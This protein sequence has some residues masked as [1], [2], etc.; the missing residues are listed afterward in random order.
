M[1]SSRPACPTVRGRAASSL[2]RA[3]LESPGT[4]SVI[5]IGQDQPLVAPEG[6]DVGG[7]ALQIDVVFG[8]DLEM[9]GDGWVN[10]RE[11]RP[12]RAHLGPAD[13]GIGQ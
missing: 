2:A 3:S 7:L 4:V 11:L 5:D 6:I 9:G 13:L 1:P 12:D 8:I 10:G